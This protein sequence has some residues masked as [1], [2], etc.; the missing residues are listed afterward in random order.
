MHNA[1]YQVL[2]PMAKIKSA[3]LGKY[4]IDT[5]RGYRKDNKH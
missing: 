1:E 2:K 5:L 4:L 3:D